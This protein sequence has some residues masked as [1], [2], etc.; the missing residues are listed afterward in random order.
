MKSDDIRQRAGDPLFFSG[1]LILLEIQKRYYISLGHDCFLYGAGSIT[2]VVQ[3]VRTRM[4]TP[5]T[6]QIQ[7]IN[8]DKSF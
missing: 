8:S 2:P 5:K 4:I 7:I 6:T 3:L 1:G